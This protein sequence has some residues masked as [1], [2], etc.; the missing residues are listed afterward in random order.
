MRRAGG[1]DGVALLVVMVLMGIMMTAGFA[2]ASTVNTQTRESRVQRVRDSSFNLAESAL[3]SQLQALAREWPGAGSDGLAGH[4][5][6]YATCTPATPTA[7]CPQSS[8]LVAQGSPDLAGASWQTSIR[9]NGGVRNFYSDAT[10]ANEPGYDRNKDNRLWVRAQGTVGGRRRTIVAQVRAE[11]QAEAIPKA[12]LI[13]GRLDLDNNGNKDLIAANG[14]LVA[15][16]CT[17]VKY[18]SA[19]LGHAFGSGK[20]KE[21]KDLLSFLATQVTN[22]SFATGYEAGD[23]R[24]ALSVEARARIKATAIANGTYYATGCPPNLVGSVVYVETASGCPIYNNVAEINSAQAPG[25]LVVNSGSIVLGGNSVYHGVVYGVNATNITGDVVAT[26]GTSRIEGA[27]LLDG[28]TSVVRI[29]A[30]GLNLSFDPNAFGAVR[31]Y[32][33][34]GVVQ[35]TFR[36][37]RG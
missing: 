21:E 28:T 6:P 32:G 3:N 20:Y 26:Q 7:R 15:V 5:A 16:R 1:E 2:L 23:P 19:C 18:D 34:A 22:A 37:I 24:P 35:N 27:V 10:T 9:D 36:E 8:A 25:L 33:A 4:P 17:L 12:A 31:S 11:T 13:A 29:G 30:S 14:G